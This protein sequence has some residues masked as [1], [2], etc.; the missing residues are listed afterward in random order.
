MNRLE[1]EAVESI[2]GLTF[3]VLESKI[4]V[5]SLLEVGL[6]ADDERVF[7]LCVNGAFLLIVFELVIFP[8]TDSDLLDRK[9]FLLQL[10][11]NLTPSL[12]RMAL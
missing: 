11:R 6:I 8:W 12:L 9:D 5:L 3:Y 7:H 10:S 4:F 2:S 1:L